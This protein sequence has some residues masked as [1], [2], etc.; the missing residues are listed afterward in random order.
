MIWA[1]FLLI[2][3]LVEKLG[4]IDFIIKNKFLS[5]IYLPVIIL[6]SWAIFNTNI[7]TLG[8]LAVYFSRLFPFFSE[9]PEYVEKSD[10]MRHI[11][12][13][14]V[15]MAVGAVFLTPLP[16]KVY[17]KCKNIKP[18]AITVMLALFW[19]SVYLIFCE[20]ANPMVY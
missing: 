10:W 7:L 16:R 4:A 17:E 8:D 15:Y 3:I 19:L 14:G 11:N 12:D 1:A 9:L 18:L 2:F 20:G 6:I 13:V 5:H